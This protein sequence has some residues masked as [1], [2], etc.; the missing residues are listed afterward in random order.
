V[1][2]LFLELRFSENTNQIVVSG[3]Y[4]SKVGRVLYPPML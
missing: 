1:F 2:S 4:P 3:T